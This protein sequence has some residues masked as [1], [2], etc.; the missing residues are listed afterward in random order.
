MKKGSC[1]GLQVVESVHGT[2]YYHLATEPEPSRPLAPIC[3]KT[4]PLMMR[5]KIPLESWGLVT[6]LNERYC[7]GCEAAWKAGTYHG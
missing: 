4:T 7:E 2:F 1:C 3:G 5:T 6:H